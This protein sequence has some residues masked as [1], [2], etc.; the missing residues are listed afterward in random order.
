V[1]SVFVFLLALVLLPSIAT[2]S[3]RCS[4][5]DLARYECCCPA[6]RHAAAHGE[7]VHED[8]KASMKAACCCTVTQPLSAQADRS[9]TSTHVELQPQLVATVVTLTPIVFSSDAMPLLDRRRAQR[10]PPTSLFARRCSLL[11]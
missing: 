5:D 2:A 8:S 9:S 10:D 1:R 7:Q 3:Y 11:I 6:T 4:I